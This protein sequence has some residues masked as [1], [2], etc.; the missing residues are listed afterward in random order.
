MLCLFFDREPEDRLLRYSRR[1]RED[2][3]QVISKPAPPN[4]SSISSAN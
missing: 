4:M 1:A 2:A 3:R